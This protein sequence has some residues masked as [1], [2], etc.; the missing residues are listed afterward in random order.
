MQTKRYTTITNV[1]RCN[2][3]LMYDR[4]T[5]RAAVFYGSTH[6]GNTKSLDEARRL[7]RRYADYADFAASSCCCYG[8]AF[9]DDIEG[10]SV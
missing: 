9:A 6:L 10:D 3:W 7:I 8:S 2:G 5:G 1:A 4:V